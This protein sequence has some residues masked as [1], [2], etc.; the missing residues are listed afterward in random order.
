MFEEHEKAAFSQSWDIAT[1]TTDRLFDYVMT[2]EPHKIEGTMSLNNA[3]RV[4]GL[5]SR[6]M[7]EMTENIVKNIENLEDHKRRIKDLDSKAVDLEKNLRVNITTLEMRPLDYPRTVCTNGNCIETLF[8]EQAR[9][10]HKHYRQ[11]CHPHCTVKGIDVDQVGFEGL[12]YCLAMDC[13]TCLVCGHSYK[14]HMHMTYD[15]IQVP[16]EKFNDEVNN[17]LNDNRDEKK[18][19]E[20]RIKTLDDIIRNMKVEKM[21]LFESSAKFGSFLKQNAILPYNDAVL[22]YFKMSI[23]Q[24]I[25]KVF[26]M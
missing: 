2:L 23:S 13:T 9:I 15:L 7:S 10:S 14:E 5:M 17:K 26:S 18:T 25:N 24:V 21:K 19:K 12:K 11:Q 16:F 4:I 22:E 20:H 1:R 8:D 3:R 6:P